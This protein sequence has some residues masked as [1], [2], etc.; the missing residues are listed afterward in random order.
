MTH[1]DHDGEWTTLVSRPPGV[2]ERLSERLAEA[3]FSG[4]VALGDRLPAE[5]E[6]AAQ[7]RVSRTA[8]RDA[9]HELE[10]KGLVERTP[11]RGTIVISDQRPAV[12]DLLGHLSPDERSLREVLDFRF[13]IEPPIAFRAAQRATA[14][15]IA[16]LDGIADGFGHN[17]SGQQHAELDKRFH[18]VVA[19]AT[20]NPLFIRLVDV[21]GTWMEESRRSALMTAHRRDASRKGHA[22]ILAAIKSHD[23]DAAANAMQSHIEEVVTAT[24]DRDPRTTGVVRDAERPT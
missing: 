11:G 13:A 8:L 21:A 1:D 18:A 5:R 14:A 23:P 10:L 16:M 24:L 15:D 20:H 17:I 2:S 9:L 3:I 19:R 22:S 12:A 7:L 6:L 4:H